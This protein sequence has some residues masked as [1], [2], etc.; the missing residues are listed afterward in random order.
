MIDANMGFLLFRQGRY[1]DAL[2]MQLA[3]REGFLATGQPDRQA[4]S[5]VDLGYCYSALGMYNEA[6]SFYQEA[7]RTLSELNMRSELLWGEVG[8]VQALLNKGELEQAAEQL[9]DL[10][11]KHGPVAETE[12]NQHALAVIWL[13]RAQVLGRLAVGNAPAQESLELCRRAKAIFQK[14]KLP[15]WYAQSLLLE[16]E[17]LRQ[18]QE[19][20]EAEAVYQA[21]REALSRL[22][23][24]HLWYQWYYGMGRLKQQQAGISGKPE[25]ET[26]LEAA[27]QEYMQAVEQVETI[28]A[29]L[30]P[31]EWR[32]A[33]MESG[34]GA[35]EAL[36]TLCLQDASNPQRVEEAFSYVERSKSRTL[37]DLLSQNLTQPE[38]GQNE[39]QAHLARRIEDLRRKLNWFYSQMHNQQGLRPGEGSQRAVALEV[40]EVSQQLETRE[41]ELVNLLRRYRPGLSPEVS[42]GQSGQIIQELRAYLTEDQQIIEYYVLDNQILAFLIDKA[43]LRVYTRLCSLEQVTDLQELLNFQINKFNLGQSYTDRHMETLRRSFDLYLQQL[44]RLLIA[45]LASRLTARQLVIVPH[46]NLHTL[47]FHAL[48][49]G[50]QYLIER[51]KL[52]YAPSAAVLLHCLKQPERPAQ[53]LLAL[54]VPDEQ[55]E[56]AEAEVRG[57]QEFFPQA[58]LLVGSEATMEALQANL[59]WCDILHLASHGIFRED[60]PLFS[61]L[62]LADGW[63]SVQDV[64]NWRFQP[65]LVTLSA[66]Q[67]G[68]A[69]PLQGDELLGLARGF[70]SA[71]AYALVVSLWS[72]SDEVTAY[73]MHLFYSNLAQGESRAAALRQAILKLRCDKR[74]AHPHYWAAF[75]LVGHP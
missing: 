14:L 24:P 45:P 71:G 75:V 64:M 28:R 46:G 41:R 16:A 13:Y 17:L 27:R 12:Q 62:K 26:L 19:W 23:L 21:A 42:A 6:L 56:G 44:Y 54:A 36:V 68:L 25:Q 72:V 69:R 5:E 57:L 38:P 40:E 15:D 20:A 35:Y 11:E 52:S 34:L 60:N 73:L 18:G 8:R 33:F 66:C 1:D 47:P 59:G 30:R 39:E 48:H 65:T 51:F 67:T 61:L 29:R 32:G 2:T 7:T 63:L 37:L 31:E 74:Y 3:A 70:L 10:V 49:D 53:K 43:G 50:E 9:Q 55:L 4:V 58:R 22:K